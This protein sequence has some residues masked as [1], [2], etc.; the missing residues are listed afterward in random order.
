VR[1][2][3]VPTGKKKNARPRKKENIMQKRGTPFYQRPP[4]SLE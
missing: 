3:E 1:L 2:D 4:T